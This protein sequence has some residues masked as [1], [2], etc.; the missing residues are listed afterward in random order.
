[1]VPEI[2][3]KGD[4]QTSPE[5]RCPAAP[6]GRASF[7]SRDAS[8]EVCFGHEMLDANSRATVSPCFPATAVPTY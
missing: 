2:C 8:I 7:G 6:T 5:N 4:A 3:A 1:M